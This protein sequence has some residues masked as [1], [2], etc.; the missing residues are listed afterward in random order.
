MVGIEYS[1]AGLFVEPF[2]SSSA[3]VS[4]YDSSAVVCPEAN[5][6]PIARKRA[7]GLLEAC[8]WRE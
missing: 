1:Y 2:F 4:F 6:S 7:G 8:W 5:W 3:V